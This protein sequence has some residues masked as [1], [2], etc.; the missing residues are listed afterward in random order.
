MAIASRTSASTSTGQWKS[1]TRRLL[2]PLAGMFLLFACKPPE[3]RSY[4]EITVDATPASM[5][6]G[7]AQEMK[8]D[9]S[10]QAAT[11][12]PGKRA[13]LSWEIPKGWVEQGA[14]GMRLA[15]LK[16]GHGDA[17]L[18]VS[19]ISL[20]G[21]GGGLS[22]NVSRWAGQIG[23]NLD[24]GELDAFVTSLP[25]VKAEGLEAHVVDFHEKVGTGD[26]PS[27][28]AA[29]VPTGGRTY[30]FKMQGK[31]GQLAPFREDFKALCESLHME[32]Q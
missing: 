19:V 26:A 23:L 13:G 7:L 18:E 9:V 30:F 29:I 27:M 3:K 4:L 15:T 8:I 2:L 25:K 16:T 32:K 14:S 12:K 22:G 20:E 6:A 28:L 24:A 11:A 17:D 5:N 31:R 10:P 21:D 1:P